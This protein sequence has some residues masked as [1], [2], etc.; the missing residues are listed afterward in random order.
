LIAAADSSVRRKRTS[1]FAASTFAEPRRNA[2]REGRDVLQIAR[3]RAD[4]RNA[5]QFGDLLD[6]DVGLALDNKMLIEN[7]VMMVCEGDR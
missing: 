1:A 4:A 2:R 6:R 5:Q 7:P 3:Q